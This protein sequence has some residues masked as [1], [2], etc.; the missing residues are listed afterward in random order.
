MAFV[1]VIESIFYLWR[2]T[3]DPKWRDMGWQMW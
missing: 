2:A 3:K 1:Q